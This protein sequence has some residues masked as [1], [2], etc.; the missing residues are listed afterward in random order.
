[1]K[2]I[3][4][5]LIVFSTFAVC[6]QDEVVQSGTPA[7]IE[8]ANGKKASAFL[9]KLEGGNLTFQPR[10]SP[11]SMT[12]PAEKIKSLKFSMSK[13]EFDAFREM[14]V[15]TSEE[16]SEIY[17]IPD[18]GNAEKLELIFKKT[19]NNIAEISY[20]GDHAGYVSAIEPIMRDRDQYMAI[21]NNLDDLYIMLMESYRKLENF[22]AAKKC[23]ANLQESSDEIKIE[24]AKVT[25]GL[26]AISEND[27]STADAIRNELSS[28]AAALYM[29]ASIERVNKNYKQ[30]IQTVTTIIADHANDLEWMPKSELLNAYLYLEM[31]G[32][33]SVITTNSALNTARQVK[34]I[35]AGSSVGG[36]ARIFWASLGGE[37]I[38]AEEIIAKAERVA[39][40]KLAKE[41]RAEAEKVRRAEAKAKREAAAAEK[42]AAKATAASTN[43]N[44]TTEN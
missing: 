33:N 21:D 19:L 17:V 6:A 23:A 43:L 7:L 37:K 30:A 9:Q 22:T 11:N 15:I 2:R 32:S 31:T 25:K 34:N 38:E 24:K 12:V 39:A 18:L 1:M 26:I 28:E 40:E 29:Q 5:S 3:L 13:V 20:Q 16:V 35:Y 42:A 8:V 4:V 44:T 41:K 36:D 14:N 27:L 10:K